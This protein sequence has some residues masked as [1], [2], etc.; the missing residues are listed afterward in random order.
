MGDVVTVRLGVSFLPASNAWQEVMK[1]EGMEQAPWMRW[2]GLELKFTSQQPT[3]SFMLPGWTEEDIE[4]WETFDTEFNMRQTNEDKPS[5]QPFIAH[6]EFQDP[7]VSW[8]D[9][10]RHEEAEYRRA[11]SPALTM[12]RSLEVLGLESLMCGDCGAG[13]RPDRGGGFPLSISV[14]GTYGT[15]TEYDPLLR[16]TLRSGFRTYSPAEALAAALQACNEECPV[17]GGTKQLIKD[18]LQAATEIALDLVSTPGYTQ[19]DPRL[20]GEAAKEE[21]ERLARKVKALAKAGSEGQALQLALEM[22]A[23]SSDTSLQ[24]VSSSYCLTEETAQLTQAAKLYVSQ[25]LVYGGK[26]PAEI[27]KKMREIG[28]LV[29]PSHPSFGNLSPEARARGCRPLALTGNA[30]KRHQIEDA[31][32]ASLWE[33]GRQVAMVLWACGLCL[34]LDVNQLLLVAEIPLIPLRLVWL[35]LSGVWTLLRGTSSRGEVRETPARAALDN[36]RTEPASPRAAGGSGKGRKGPAG[37]PSAAASKSTKGAGGSRGALK[38]RSGSAD[39]A[40]PSAAATANGGSG[41]QQPAPQQPPAP[42]PQPQQ[43][44]AK[45]AGAK[46]RR[47]S[48]AYGPSGAAPNGTATLTST[49]LHPAIREPSTPLP[50]AT[51]ASVP[52]AQPSAAPASQPYQ[53]SASAAAA[54]A[55]AWD[56]MPP[57]PAAAGSASTAAAASS[58]PAPVSSSAPD[59]DDDVS[60]L[61][62]MC[63]DGPRR[64]GFLHGTTVHTGVFGASRPALPRLAPPGAQGGWVGERSAPQGGRKLWRPGVFCSGPNQHA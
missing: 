12:Y 56:F 7:E 32:R 5:R 62:V 31:T 49:L 44:N 47:G 13:S 33:L 23:W 21:R 14:D 40:G 29:H 15:S 26:V 54:F 38:G 27:T 51:P 46:K 6:L 16:Y 45:P 64:F 37:S 18:A 50:A 30:A 19:E 24:P 10:A 63:L 8:H 59:D 43:H 57:P 36:G 42:P 22:A 52:S 48:S 20:Y 3:H 17:K 28:A 2:L 9:L 41:R 61:C 35:A 58:P 1:A 39:A 60:R 55:P 11:L 53:S 34:L 4:L 25:S